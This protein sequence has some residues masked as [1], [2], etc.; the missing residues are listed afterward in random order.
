[1]HRQEVGR[2]LPMMPFLR[3]SA[4]CIWHHLRVSMPHI[5]V[6]LPWKRKRFELRE[7]RGVVGVRLVSASVARGRRERAARTAR[8]NVSPGYLPPKS[9]EP[10]YTRINIDENAVPK[11]HE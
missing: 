5:L 9:L 1:M 6:R 11:V 7:L 2:L 10:V 3:V 8:E 4:V